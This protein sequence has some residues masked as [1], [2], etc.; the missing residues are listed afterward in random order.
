MGRL[1]GGLGYWVVVRSSDVYLKNVYE[2]KVCKWFIRLLLLYVVHY[3]RP[4][5]QSI[6]HRI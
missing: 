3:L 1:M 6:N 5:Y 2:K 4:P